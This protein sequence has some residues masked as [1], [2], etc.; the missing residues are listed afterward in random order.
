MRIA[1]LGSPDSWYC[2][3]LARAAGDR[4][5][6]IACPFAAMRSTIRQDGA[7]FTAGEVPLDEIDCL[8]VRTMAPGSL[9]QVVF[10]MD[11]LARLAASGKLVINPPAAVECAVDKYLATAR[12]QAAGLT[13]PTTVVC[14]GVDEAMAAFDTLGGDV[15]L[16][17]VFGS[18]GRGITRITDEA[19]ALRAFKL[20]TELRSLSYLQRFVPHHGYDIRVL[21][22]GEEML[23]M[24]RHNADD[25]RTNISRGA[26]GEAYELSED[27]RRMARVAA[28][29]IGAPLA[30]VDLL[31]GCDGRLYALEVNAVPG[32]RALAGVLGIDVSGRVLEFLEG[33]R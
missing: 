24:R 26:R 17:P 18:E 33:M 20:L 31:P 13:V 3:D 27:E 5:E 28:E 29:A 9:E 30:A 21:V 10:R 14:Q 7:T 23:A 16:K 19:F 2:H 11:M 15:V 25:W 32:W 1:F 6:M 4:H 12:L 8:L 22:I